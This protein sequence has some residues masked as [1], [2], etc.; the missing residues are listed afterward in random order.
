MDKPC[1]LPMINGGKNE[2]LSSILQC[3]IEIDDFGLY[4]LKKRPDS[5]RS[6]QVLVKLINEV[7]REM[8]K[9]RESLVGRYEQQ[10]PF[11]LEFFID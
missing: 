2:Y 3:F 1:M 4:F 5:I 9:K 6:N 11:N 10:T 7:L 8:I